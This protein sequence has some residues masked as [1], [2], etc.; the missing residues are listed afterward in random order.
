MS[1]AAAISMGFVA[2]VGLSVLLYCLICFIAYYQKIF[3]GADMIAE[4]VKAFEEAKEENQKPEEEKSE[5]AT[6]SIE[7]NGSAAQA[8]GN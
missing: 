6:S 3:E 8:A 2:G 1:T 7:E 5:N 4:A